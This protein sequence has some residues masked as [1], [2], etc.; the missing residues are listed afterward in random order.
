[1]TTAFGRLDRQLLAE[2]DAITP[3]TDGWFTF[4]P[5]RVELVSG[6]VCERVYC[7]DVDRQRVSSV[8]LEALA[9]SGA[10]DPSEVR[11]IG[12]SSLRLPAELAQR[13]YDAGES[14]MGYVIFGVVLRDGRILQRL[15]GNFVDFPT[16][17]EGV[18]TADI[19]DVVVGVD[20]MSYFRDRPPGADEGSASFRWLL[21]RRGS[22]EAASTWSP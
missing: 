15:T 3:T 4:V 17:P 12:E 9:E 18:Q 16:L 22:I 13:V 5:A 19:A 8:Q 1:M 11:H 21:F 7:L 6:G 14:G 10:I 20:R 2:I